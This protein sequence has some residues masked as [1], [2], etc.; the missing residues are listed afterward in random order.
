MYVDLKL[1]RGGFAQQYSTLKWL[2]GSA[3]TALIFTH[4]HIFCKQK[5]VRII[6]LFYKA[7]GLHTEFKFYLINDADE[8]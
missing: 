1:I 4:S 5:I 2:C 7:H 8:N 3:E 6:K